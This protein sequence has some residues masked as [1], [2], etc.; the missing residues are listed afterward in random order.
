MA[1]KTILHFVVNLKV[2]FKALLVLHYLILE[3]NAERVMGYLSSHPGIFNMTN[4]RDSGSGGQ[5]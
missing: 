5:G 3:G 2:A 4:Y 1:G